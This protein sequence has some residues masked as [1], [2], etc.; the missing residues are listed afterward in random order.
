MKMKFAT[1]AHTMR[2]A[3]EVKTLITSHPE[4]LDTRQRDIFDQYGQLRTDYVLQEGWPID[5]S[6][7][8]IDVY[9]T[10]A[11]S[12][13]VIAHAGGTAYAGLRLTSIT[14]LWGSLSYSMWSHAVER[15]QFDAM[16]SQK[17]SDIKHIETVG[18]SGHLWDVTRLISAGALGIDNSQLFKSRSRVGVISAMAAAVTITDDPLSCW[19]FTV[20][21]GAL[22]FMRRNGFAPHVLAHGKISE[23]DVDHAYFGYVNPHEV[24]D[25]MRKSSATTYR[26][27]RRAMAQ[28]HHVK[29]E[30]G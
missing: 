20:S 12:Y 3:A 27:A 29:R 16:L 21:A 25:Q 17:L 19:I 11:E 28:T 14:S 22:R 18:Q 24:L 9:D 4:A 30:K 6:G 5:A 15:G 2:A 7:V 8:D 26:F 13:Y 1:I 23:E 10:A